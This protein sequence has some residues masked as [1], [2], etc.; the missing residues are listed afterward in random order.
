M[1]KDCIAPNL[2]EDLYL[3]CWNI[4]HI[5]IFQHLRDIGR[6]CRPIFASATLNWPCDTCHSRDEEM[7]NRI[8]VVHMD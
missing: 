4:N 8:S 5:R 6:R 3:K 2:I 1:R 7:K